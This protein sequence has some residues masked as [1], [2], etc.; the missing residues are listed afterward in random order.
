[1]KCRPKHGA[2]G[3]FVDLPEGE[4]KLMQLSAACK[5]STSR[6]VVGEP[7]VPERRAQPLPSHD[8]ETVVR[9]PTQE[10]EASLESK[11]DTGPSYWEGL[12]SMLWWG[13]DTD[14]AQ[15]AIGE[16][17]PSSSLAPFRCPVLPEMRCAV[18]SES[19]RQQLSYKTVLGSRV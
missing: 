11:E 12:L 6:R 16:P 15:K 5:A 18:W 17:V 7:R 3:A 14:E 10:D 19:I 8:Q 13:S 2:Q 9:L 4:V 1:M